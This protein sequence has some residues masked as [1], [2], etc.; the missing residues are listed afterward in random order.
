MTSVPGWHGAAERPPRSLRAVGM[1]Q[2]LGDA[3]QA[4]GKANAVAGGPGAVHHQVAGLGGKP[5]LVRLQPAVR[6]GQAHQPRRHQVERLAVG[7][8]AAA[9]VV[10]AAGQ[11]EGLLHL[12]H[13]LPHV[14]HAPK[15][16][17]GGP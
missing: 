12:A 9:E 2:G 3:F 8:V 16:V 13:H 11:R 7:A 17:G 1:V 6:V 10:D 5:L 4:V 15:L 14:G